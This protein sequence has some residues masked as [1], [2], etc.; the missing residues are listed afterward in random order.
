MSIV[1]DPA[2]VAQWPRVVHALV[3]HRHP[4]IEDPHGSVDSGLTD[5]DRV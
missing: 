5:F 3:P 2:L 4:L 1:R